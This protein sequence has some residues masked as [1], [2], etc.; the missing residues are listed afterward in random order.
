MSAGRHHPQQQRH[1]QPALRH[2]DD[3]DVATRRCRRLPAG[4]WRSQS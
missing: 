2:R 1:R 4:G 3:L